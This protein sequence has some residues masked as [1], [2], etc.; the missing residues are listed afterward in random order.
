MQYV[1]RFS[2][3]WEIT[4]PVEKSYILLSCW[5]WSNVR[6]TC[7]SHSVLQHKLDFWQAVKLPQGVHTLL[8]VGDTFPGWT[9]M[10]TISKIGWRESGNKIIK[11]FHWSSIPCWGRDQLFHRTHVKCFAMWI[12]SCEKEGSYLNLCCTLL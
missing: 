2:F 11:I 5:G 1:K 4:T 8:L 10:G 7:C 6:Q 12:K 9:E 3:P